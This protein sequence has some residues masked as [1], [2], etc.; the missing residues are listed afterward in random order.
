MYASQWVHIQEELF[1]F[2]RGAKRV[3]I[4]AL[5]EIVGEDELVVEHVRGGADAVYARE[6]IRYAG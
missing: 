1:D 5:Y 4:D 3:S 2:E 6:Q